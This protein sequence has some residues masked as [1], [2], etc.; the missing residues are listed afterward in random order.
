M[1]R[2]T[3]PRLR[4]VG[5]TRKPIRVGRNRTVPDTLEDISHPRT[6]R[7]ADFFVAKDRP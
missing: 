1:N 4:S 2:R 6:P 5:R 7:L 3:A